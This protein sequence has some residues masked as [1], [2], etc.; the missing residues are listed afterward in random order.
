M[1]LWGIWL[2]T[3]VCL[4]PAV[5]QDDEDW[6][7]AF[8]FTS[9]LPAE[10]AITE[11]VS[12]LTRS[13]SSF[14]GLIAVLGATNEKLVEAMEAYLKNPG[15]EVLA[16]RLEL[17]LA[18][19]AEQIIEQFEE[20]S[21]QRDG[22][23][24]HFNL[25][26]RKL[27]QTRDAVEERAVILEQK[28]TLVETAVARNDRALTELAVRIKDAEARGEDSDALRREFVN[29]RKKLEREQR[30]HRRYLRFQQNYAEMQGNVTN[31][32]DT[33]SDLQ[34]AC[35][36]LLDN[37]QLERTVL[38]DQIRYQR[39]LIEV[40]QLIR[41]SLV[42]GQHA[43]EKVADTVVQLYFKVDT[44]TELHTR[45]SQHMATVNHSDLAMGVMQNALDD[46]GSAS[47][48]TDEDLDAL[49]QQYAEM[50]EVPGE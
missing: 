19:H 44:F 16:S 18:R 48:T 23:N 32:A 29:Q 17:E 10:V 37:L 11:D 8:A 24:F 25:I 27:E 49:I 50:A 6:S 41:D 30:N 12:A 5:A 39:E 4:A 40:R 26:A 47:A 22:I 20:V 28:V 46:V 43:M 14:D 34:V 7:T 31:L 21:S 35:V 38:L 42:S 3:V 36:D 15:D 33:F 13:V 2:L 9:E 1:R 45:I